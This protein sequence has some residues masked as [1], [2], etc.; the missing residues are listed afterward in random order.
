MKARR[1]INKQ[2]LAPEACSL[3][4]HAWA[5][6]L[7]CRC[8]AGLQ[9]ASWAACCCCCAAGSPA[10]HAHRTEEEQEKSEDQYRRTNC[11]Y[12]SQNSTNQ[13]ENRALDSQQ[14]T[15]TG[16]RRILRNGG[17]NLAN[18]KS[19]ENTPKIIQKEKQSGCNKSIRI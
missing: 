12:L 14:L 3:L 13:K 8:S 7:A 11:K 4:T 1:E 17:I 16:P 5:T 2:E 9:A 10:P 15:V 18:R 19:H 6:S